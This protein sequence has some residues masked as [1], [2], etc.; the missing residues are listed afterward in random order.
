MWGG[1]REISQENMNREACEKEDVQDE[2]GLACLRQ[3]FM[4]SGR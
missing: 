1:Y 4:G 3:G 2:P